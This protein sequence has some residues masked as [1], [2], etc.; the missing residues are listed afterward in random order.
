MS[1]AS[2]KL[3][4]YQSPS[5]LIKETSLSFI[6]NEGRTEVQAELALVRNGSASEVR[7]DGEGLDTLSVEIDG[8]PVDYRIEGEQLVFTAPGEQFVLH[9]RVAIVPEENT[10]LEGLYKSGD[11]YCTQCE[12]EG[13]RRIT[14]FIDRPDVLSV[15]TV[16]IDAPA[17][18][19]TLLS[20]G[21][22]RSVQTQANGRRVATWH[23]PHPKPSYLFALVA[24]DLVCREDRYVTLQGQPVDLRVFTR[25]EDA[26]KVDFA[27]E[28][29]KAA[30]HWDEQ[31][32][33]RE[34]D[35]EV[36]N[37]VAV[38]DFNMGAMENKG[39]NI[40]NTSCVLAT[41]DIATDDA[42]QRVE[43]IIGHEYFHNWSGNR[44]TCRDWFQ[45][46]L[47]EGFTVHRDAEFTADLHSRA[48]KRIQ[49][50]SFL[51]THQFAE[52]AGPTRHPVRPAEYQEISNFYTVT[53]Y[54]KGAEVVGMLATLLGDKFRQ[55][56]DLYFERFD[57][58]AVTC[59]DF[60]DCMQE[61]SGLDLEQFRRWY[62]APGTPKVRVKAQPS[63]QG[64]RAVLTQSLE[65][66]DQPLMIPLR[67]QAYTQT[68][69]PCGDS[70]LVVL[71]ETDTELFFDD[72]QAAVLSV[73]QG[74]TAPVLI[75]YPLSEADRVTLASCD[76]DPV[77]RWDATQYL[78][79]D[80]WRSV[81]ESQEW[82]GLASLKQSLSHALDQAFEDPA[83]AAEVLTLPDAAQMMSLIPE[84]VDPIRLEQA[85]QGIHQRI[86]QALGEQIQGVLDQL[87]AATT[88]Q[89][90]GEQPGRR[91]LWSVLAA[92]LVAADD[93]AI[94]DGVSRRFVAADNLTDRLNSMRAAGK[95]QHTA[96]L[97]QNML[98]V[99]IAD[100]RHEPLMVDLW[101]QVQAAQ[102]SFADI[103]RL[104]QHEDYHLGNPNRA[105]SV[106]GPWARGNS[107]AF[108]S[109]EGYALFAQTIT[110]L[111]Q[112]NPQIAARLVLPL[113]QYAR[114]CEPYHSQ[115]KSVLE[116]LSRDCGSKDMA[117][118][119]SKALK[120]E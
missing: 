111:E 66:T 64:L 78:M 75:D 119:V 19:P 82:G 88:Y 35:L 91:R 68:G 23:D 67:I 29:I 69:T 26:S 12:A 14:W 16:Q 102:G 25:T 52:D 49:D 62:S 22:P 90:S 9:T 47:K 28:S 37:V 32:F 11:M 58:Q 104:L 50:V 55:G 31:R 43:A 79:K 115:A 98:Q 17:D 21:N 73:N 114:W 27:I 8:Q 89:P 65:G 86:G 60:V 110:Q 40:F 54:E 1:G 96:A 7:L 112:I 108:H 48:V 34:Y 57:G 87:P 85:R 4:E 106:L 84:P 103:Q 99:F 39:L 83:Y 120:T 107:E 41:P 118:I 74:F 42:Y 51:R 72:P 44:V 77:N 116:Q 56:S 61:V 76:L 81:Y 13:F 80:L 36:F 94:G 59:D 95:S 105:R 38:G 10:Y 101:F 93:A 53:V 5:W 24:G 63:E 117:E 6:L 113:T 97:Y 109:A 70:R 100:W 92:L 3:S 46:S 71:T 30:M 18:Y 33:G 20:N 15:W 2:I 45:L